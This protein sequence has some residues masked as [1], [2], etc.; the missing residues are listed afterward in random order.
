M[1][2]LSRIA[3]ANSFTAGALRVCATPPSPELLIGRRVICH[4]VVLADIHNAG[5]VYVPDEGEVIVDDDLVTARSFA[6]VEGYF[7]AIVAA[8]G[9]RQAS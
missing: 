7:W 5:A 1:I 8:A 6:N 2:R 3:F 4:T 9:E